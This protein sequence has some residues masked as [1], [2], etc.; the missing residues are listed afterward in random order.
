MRP[1]FGPWNCRGVPR[2]VVFTASERL[3]IACFL[4]ALAIVGDIGR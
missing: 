1:L 4:S 2:V 3:I